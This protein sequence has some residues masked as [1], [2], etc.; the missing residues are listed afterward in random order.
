[1]TFMHQNAQKIE[2]LRHFSLL[3]TSYPWHV[4]YHILKECHP[5]KFRI[6]MLKMEATSFGLQK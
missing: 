6:S 2:D 1:M 5:V 4:I 3:T